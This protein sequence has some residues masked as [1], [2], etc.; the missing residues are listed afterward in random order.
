MNATVGKHHRL[1]STTA[2]HAD[3]QGAATVG[4]RTLVEQ[5][6]VQLEASDGELRDPAKV[7]AHAAAGTAGG[8]GP[9]PHGDRI[10]R[11]FGSHD[12]TGVRAHTDGA[13]GAANAAM[14]SRAYARGNDIAFG[15]SP[16]LHT[17]AH[18]AAHVVQQRGG[19]QLKDGVGTG[20][21]AYERH[22]DAVADKV[23]AGESAEALLSTMAGPSRA[24]GRAAVQHAVQFEDAPAPAAAPADAAAAPRSGTSFKFT[25][26]TWPLGK[27]HKFIDANVSFLKVSLSTAA[28]FKGSVGVK[29][30]DG[31]G[32][33]ATGAAV[34]PAD[35]L[36]ESKTKVNSLFEDDGHDLTFDPNGWVGV[37]DLGISGV[38]KGPGKGSVG[39]VTFFQ[40]LVKRGKNVL[41]EVKLSVAAFSW[42]GLTWS[43]DGPKPSAKVFPLEATGELNL[44][45][46]SGQVDLGGSGCLAAGG[47]VVGQLKGN[48]AIDPVRLAMMMSGDLAVGAGAEGLA[49][50][51]GVLGGE[52]L[53]PLAAGVI[54][55][56]T[57][58]ELLDDMDVEQ[59]THEALADVNRASSGFENE[60]TEPGHAFK[61]SLLFK[62]DPYK[63]GI[64]AASG[65]KSQFFS[66]FLN[67]PK[68]GKWRESTPDQ[69]QQRSFMDAAY[70]QW[71]SQDAMAK[72]IIA[73]TSA[74]M[75]VEL[76]AH[77]MGDH[78]VAYAQRQGMFSRRDRILRLFE[79]LWPGA[80]WLDPMT[81]L[82]PIAYSATIPRACYQIASRLH[83]SAYPADLTQWASPPTLI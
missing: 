37:K 12:I 48:V 55:G 56:V 24:G 28:Q 6:P 9:L 42:D 79:R 14:G 3:N 43:G 74:R 66:T 81:R 26:L 31:T 21:D 7:H 39:K 54:V 40:G 38:E 33:K 29:D 8:G 27:D 36:A 60:M 78:F 5:L 64:E 22:A 2:G 83:P 30:A 23:V 4:K 73:A 32:A 57:V 44:L 20:G 13:A 63:K 15:G 53:A 47:K 67:H 71:I 61:P 11:L 1:E 17:A 19:V 65:L 80:I 41:G 52:V 18:E 82:R 68:L 75:K 69:G 34:V 76:N 16:D 70:Q 45:T 51:L 10:Q 58:A 59:I 49:A 50:A 72:G 77:I 62:H 25:E 35:L 46:L